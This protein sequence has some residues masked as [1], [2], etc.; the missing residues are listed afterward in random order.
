MMKKIIALFCIF[1]AP[2]FVRAGSVVI[3]EVGWSGTAADDTDEWIELRN[4]G[5]QAISL[6]GWI[7]RALSDGRPTINLSGTISGSGFYLIERTSDSDISDVAADFYGSFGQY[8]SISNSGEDLELIDSGG[9]VVDTISFAGGWPAGSIGPDYF[10]MERIDPLA[11][12]SL[13]SNWAS[14]DG[15][16]RN[17]KDANGT[18]INGTPKSENSAYGAASGGPS[19]PTEEESGL[20]SSAENVVSSQPTT[21]ALKE[22]FTVYAGEDKTV[23]SGQETDFVGRTTGVSG[24]PV[25]NAQYL[26][27]FGDGS[28][29]RLKAT[30]HTY[31]YPGVYIV[32][33]NANVGE[34]SHGDYLT[35][36]VLLPQIAISEVKTGPDGFIELFNAN[37]KRTDIG[38][39]IVKDE[40]SGAVFLMPKDTFLD[41][42][43]VRVFPNS[44]TGISGLGGFIS[45]LTSNGKTVDTAKFTGVLSSGESFIRGKD[46]G[47]IKTSS[48]S[49]GA[50]NPVAVSEYEITETEGNNVGANGLT[51]KMSAATKDASDKKTGSG[52]AASLEE[53]KDESGGANNI[54]S[55]INPPP[56]G[57]DNDVSPL[58]TGESAVLPDEQTAGISF[59]GFSSYIF[60]TASLFIGAASAVGFLFLKKFF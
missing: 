52:E 44:T 56:F 35:I 8:G 3:N 16:T 58:E 20:G 21:P 5:G 13:S 57:T 12:G 59:G 27:N 36:E 29:A 47:F 33:L 7:I 25:T 9:S 15:N 28:I 26:W 39:L 32:S 38:R 23:L 46:S 48:P 54:E 11:D 42:K 1:S 40:A 50:V 24:D 34:E 31:S 14:N 30:T 43:T 41:G 53:N 19:Q 10:S 37:A 4:N 45:L 51:E 2:F 18:P 22:T 55:G 60:L 17:G 49:P 6:D